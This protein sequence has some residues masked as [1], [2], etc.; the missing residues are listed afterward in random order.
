MVWIR[1][2][3]GATMPQVEM[4]NEMNVF[5]SKDRLASRIGIYPG[6]K[7]SAGKEKPD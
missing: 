4:S 5:S 2:S 1:L 6:N 7:E 3:N